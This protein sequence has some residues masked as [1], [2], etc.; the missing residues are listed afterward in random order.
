[1]TQLGNLGDTMNL[2]QFFRYMVVGI[3]VLNPQRSCHA[4]EYQLEKEEGV[5][6]GVK[7]HIYNL[8]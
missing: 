8:G 6:E 5:K 7:Y 2:P 1:M 3:F 4:D